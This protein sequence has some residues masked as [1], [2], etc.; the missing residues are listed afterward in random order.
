MQ[1][2]EHHRHNSM[3]QGL[4]M[5]NELQNRERSWPKPNENGVYEKGTHTLAFEKGKVEVTIDTL[6]ISQGEW[7]AATSDQFGDT[8][9]GCPLYARRLYSSQQEAEID[10]LMRYYDHRLIPDE[11]DSPG[12]AQMKKAATEW[13]K[14]ELRE[15]GVKPKGKLVGWNIYLFREDPDTGEQ[16]KEEWDENRVCKIADEYFFSLRDQEEE[17]LE[18]T[19]DLP[20]NRMRPLGRDITQLL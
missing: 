12:K 20:W 11:D 16:I 15:R 13:V 1:P 18:I 9:S 4:N 17:S 2:G 8:G 7:I 14:D 3:D 19:W 6:E 5:E 10:Q